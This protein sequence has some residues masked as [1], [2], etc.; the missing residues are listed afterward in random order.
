V[1][2]RRQAVA[3]AGTMGLQDA[4]HAFER[5]LELEPDF[6]AAV[7]GAALARARLLSLR[8]DD[9]AEEFGLE[10]CER[11]VQAAFEHAPR[12]A[13]SH[14]AA[15]R[16]ATEQSDFATAARELAEAIAISPS[17][18]S[19]HALLGMLQR[20]AGR[21]DEAAMRI[22][23]A[24]ALDPATTDALL[25][26]ARHRASHARTETAER[27]S[28]DLAD[29]LDDAFAWGGNR[30][31]CALLHQMGTEAAAGRGEADAALTYL[32]RARDLGLIDL[33][34]MRHCPHLDAI[35]SHERFTD[36]LEAIRQRADALW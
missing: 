25:E 31:R 20:E 18:A 30:R 8:G 21:S 15:A 32:E 28:S 14:L 13:A 12:F 3:D 7:A 19:A 35:R 23:L 33:D 34:W 4:I 26:A 10:V 29:L 11:A 2:A 27:P 22:E 36:V 1:L 9:D 17:S 24:R 5:C 16:L 6:P